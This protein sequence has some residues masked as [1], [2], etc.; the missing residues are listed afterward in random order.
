MWLREGWVEL[1]LGGFCGSF[2][3]PM[4][5]RLPY[6]IMFFYSIAETISHVSL[7]ISDKQELNLSLCIAM[8]NK[9]VGLE[10]PT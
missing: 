5:F 2:C 9:C 3:R 6:S 8:H 10:N 1:W 7:Q 4:G